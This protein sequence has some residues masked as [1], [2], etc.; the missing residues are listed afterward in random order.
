MLEDQA[1]PRGSSSPWGPRHRGSSSA[2]LLS[3][4]TILHTHQ[5]IQWDPSAPLGVPHARGGLETAQVLSWIESVQVRPRRRGSDRDHDCDRYGEEPRGKERDRMRP[6]SP[7]PVDDL[8]ESAAALGNARSWSG[9]KSSKSRGIASVETATTTTI[10]VTTQTVIR[11]CRRVVC[12][13]KST[14]LLV[15]LRLSNG[16]EQK[17]QWEQLLEPA[18]LTAPAGAPGAPSSPPALRAPVPPPTASLPMPPSWQKSFELGRNSALLY[19]L[20]SGDTNRLHVLASLP[21]EEQATPRRRPPVIHGLC[22]LGHV[23]R[24]LTEHYD[25]QSAEEGRR[26]VEA[27]AP[28][29]S[30]EDS[31]RC[32]ATPASPGRSKQRRYAEL[33]SLDCRF[34]S[35]VFAGD[36]LLVQAWEGPSGSN[37]D[38]SVPFT[39]PTS[40]SSLSSSLPPLPIAVPGVPAESVTSAASSACPPLDLLSPSSQWSSVTVTF[41]VRDRSTGAVA[42]DR[43]CAVLRV[44]T[45]TVA[46]S[47]PGDSMEPAWGP[48]R[49]SSG[50]PSISPS[51]SNLPRRRQATVMS[52]L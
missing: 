30:S 24:I 11:Q 25:G 37:N 6:P 4:I 36:S 52:R 20:A 3:S 14:F 50:T 43:G 18:E 31:G 5:S 1:T 51:S 29:N 9:A 38:D 12:E 34:A 7:S 46:A 2:S 35:P 19:R 39:T 28:A 41:V 16:G 48:T 26:S 15:G 42:L 17:R 13:M 47:I 27:P 40:P 33:E 49:R 10:A 22:T 23:A 21:E 8:L 45:T 44:P 32:C